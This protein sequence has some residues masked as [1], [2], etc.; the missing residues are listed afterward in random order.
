MRIPEDNDYPD[1]KDMPEPGKKKKT[2]KKA[3]KDVEGFTT[4]PDGFCRCGKR[5]PQVLALRV[6]NGVARPVEEDG[7]DKGSS[8]YFVP[9]HPKDGPWPFDASRS[10][11][12]IYEFPYTLGKF[13]DKP[14]ILTARIGV[15][16]CECGNVIIYGENISTSWGGTFSQ[17]AAVLPDGAAGAMKKVMWARTLGIMP[18]VSEAALKLSWPFFPEKHQ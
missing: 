12:L 18:D 7:S 8:V 17:V 1:P 9:W 5:W 2:T 14:L 15:A 6:E 16:R 3:F 11:K 4:P 10:R 13:G